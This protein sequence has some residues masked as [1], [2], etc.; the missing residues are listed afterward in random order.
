MRITRTAFS[1]F[2]ENRKCA[3]YKTGLSQ[4]LTSFPD[5]QAP[6]VP[7]AQWTL[8]QSFQFSEENNFHGKV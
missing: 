6:R 7:G 4:K 1:R 8:P 3:S 2:P 5:T